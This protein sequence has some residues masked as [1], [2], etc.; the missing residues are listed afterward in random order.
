MKIKAQ[1]QY[2]VD[3]EDCPRCGGEHPALYFQQLSN[4]TTRDDLYGFCSERS[5]PIL[6]STEDID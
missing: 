5:E 3:V 2:I 4:P 6:I 1:R